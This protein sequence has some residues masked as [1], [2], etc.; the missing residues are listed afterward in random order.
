MTLFNDTTTAAITDLSSGTPSK[1]SVTLEGAD[2]D[3]ADQLTNCYCHH[4]EVS[5]ILIIT[6]NALLNGFPLPVSNQLNY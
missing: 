1:N 3:I 6:L 5:T 2:S 4:P